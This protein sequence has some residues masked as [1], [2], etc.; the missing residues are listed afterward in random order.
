[1]EL[2][3]LINDFIP[4]KGKRTL[5]VYPDEG[6]LVREAIASV[7][8]GGKVMV[9]CTSQ[10]A[11][12]KWTAQHLEQLIKQT[13]PDAKISPSIPKP[14]PIKTIPPTVASKILMR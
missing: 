14:S 2:W 8:N 13:I 10:Q 6:T 5:T 9:H 4:N 11:K 1:M 12:S 7:K 3:L